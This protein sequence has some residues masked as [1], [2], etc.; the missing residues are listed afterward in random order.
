MYN[1]IR[2]I[3]WTNYIRD[4]ND[5]YTTRQSNRRSWRLQS[6]MLIGLVEVLVELE[7]KI[8]RRHIDI[9]EL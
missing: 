6:N 8:L 3:S 2:L 4:H 5:S 1:R 9:I 7:T